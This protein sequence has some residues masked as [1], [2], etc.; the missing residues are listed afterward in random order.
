[1]DE[2]AELQA[3]KGRLAALPPGKVPDEV[4]NASSFVPTSVEDD[5]WRDRLPHTKNRFKGQMSQLNLIERARQK[6]LQERLEADEQKRL[7]A[8]KKERE[9]AFLDEL[10]ER[11]RQRVNTGE[12]VEVGKEGILK[13]REK[14]MKE[15]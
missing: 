9:K 2:M 5:S 4:A 12:R 6:V 3:M 10:A 14:E 1:M 15:R 11:N 8:E 7:E 13:R